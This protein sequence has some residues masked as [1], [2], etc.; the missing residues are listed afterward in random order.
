MGEVYKNTEDRTKI[1]NKIKI[2]GNKEEEINNE[3]ERKE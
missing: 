2:K 1:I 3:R